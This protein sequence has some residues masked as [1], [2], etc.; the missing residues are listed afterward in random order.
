MKEGTSFHDYFNHF[1]KII[2][3][4]LSKDVAI[5][6]VDKAFILLFSLP[7]NEHLLL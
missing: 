2:S 5:D 1:N 4:L 7:P 6:E 3:Q